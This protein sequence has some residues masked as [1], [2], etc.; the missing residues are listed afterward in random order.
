MSQI[1]AVFTGSVVAEPSRGS[2]KNGSTFVEFPVYVNHAKKNRTTGTFDKTGDVSKFR[3]TLWGE[4]ADAAN[5]AKGDLVEVS[6]TIVEKEFQKK[7][8]TMG[9][10]LQTDWVESIRVKRA[11]K[12][13]EPAPQQ[14]VP[15]FIDDGAPF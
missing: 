7:D 4:L 13:V 10:S 3:V 12:P 1:K 11:G 2:T 8:G 9:R 14:T 15:A 5:L 6:A